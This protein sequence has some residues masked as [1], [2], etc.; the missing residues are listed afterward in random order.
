MHEG[1]GESPRRDEIEG[2][3]H[4]HHSLGPLHFFIMGKICTPRPHQE[5]E[6]TAAATSWWSL[7]LSRKVAHFESLIEAL[8][9]AA[10][11]ATERPPASAMARWRRARRRRTGDEGHSRRRRRRRSEAEEGIEEDDEHR[12]EWS[13][14]TG[15]TVSLV[16]QLA[17]EVERIRK[18]RNRR[19]RRLMVSQWGRI[20]PT[21]WPF[22][23]K[24]RYFSELAREHR[25]REA[26]DDEWTR[27]HK[28]AR[29]ETDVGS[30]ETVRRA[31]LRR[32]TDDGGGRVSAAP[33]GVERAR[34]DQTNHQA[35]AHVADEA[36]MVA[37]DGLRRVADGVQAAVGSEYV[38]QAQLRCSD[39]GKRK[40]QRRR[41]AAHKRKMK[42]SRELEE[43]RKKRK[44]EE[45]PVMDH[46]AKE[47]ANADQPQ[48]QS[49][50]M[51]EVESKPTVKKWQNTK[52]RVRRE[53]TKLWTNKHVK[54]GLVH[55]ERHLADREVLGMGTVMAH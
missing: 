51:K 32:R 18:R 9:A 6:E 45:L 5:R 23:T 3:C 36:E 17:S 54:R 43:E 7:P 21:M 52:W 22:D 15:S 33:S 13:E 35:C 20:D 31:G 37:A 38:G 47:E 11:A 8:A 19:R 4:L 2:L 30:P 25:L 29:E 48:E 39:E 50:E 41:R 53:L 1:V 27:W 49:N 46:Q 12:Q 14:G 34:D 42:R 44:Q 16:A 28:R 26:I 10:A 55:F 24:V 40:R